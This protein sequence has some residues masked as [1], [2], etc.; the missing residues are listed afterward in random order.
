MDLIR[1]YI[2]RM[3]F[4]RAWGIQITLF[5]CSITVSTPGFISVQWL[6]FSNGCIREHHRTLRL[7]VPWLMRWIRDLDQRIQ[8]AFNVERADWMLRDENGA[9]DQRVY[10][11]E[12]AMSGRPNRTEPLRHGIVGR[13]V[14]ISRFAQQDS[15]LSETMTWLT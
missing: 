15:T 13:M 6:S 12:R 2:G 8:A 1:L 10:R 9:F 7:H 4:A 11:S 3:D 14:R 5:G